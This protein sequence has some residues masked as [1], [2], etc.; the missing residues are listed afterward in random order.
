MKGPGHTRSGRARYRVQQAF[1]D[2]QTAGRSTP[3]HQGHPGQQIGREVHS[4]PGRAA[5]A[6]SREGLAPP[7][8]SLEDLDPVLGVSRARRGV[9][10]RPQGAAAL[11][12]RGTPKLRFSSRSTTPLGR[13]RPAV[14]ELDRI[15]DHPQAPERSQ[16]G[17]Q[18]RPGWRNDAEIAAARPVRR[19]GKD[20]RRDLIVE[21]RLLFPGIRT[22]R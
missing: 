10:R 21:H 8:R 13:P 18:A 3:G 2:P 5:L 22:C 16:R 4:S 14:R 9:E 1:H 7:N 15:G 20:L 6:R 12:H 19:E 11:L 17:A